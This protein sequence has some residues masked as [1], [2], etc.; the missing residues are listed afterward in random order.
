VLSRLA[1]ITNNPRARRDE[2]R[3]LSGST[4]PLRQLGKP[5]EARKR[6]DLALSRL[7]ELKL[8]PAD[9]IVPD[10]EPDKALRALAA[11]EAETGNIGKAVEI[12]EELH[13]KLM[14]SETKPESDLA[15][16]VNLSNLYDLISSLHRRNKQSSKADELDAKRLQLWSHWDRKLR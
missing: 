7:N 8:Y 12:Y 4:Y 15:D 3:A 2:V 10:S 11:H 9:R 5:D 13:S 16:A 6:L 14:A 1:E